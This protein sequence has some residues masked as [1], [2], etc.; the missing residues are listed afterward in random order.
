VSKNLFRAGIFFVLLLPARAQFGGN[1][2]DAI[3]YAV[4]ADGSG[5]FQAVAPFTE[6]S[7]QS[8]AAFRVTSLASV[9]LLTSEP[10]PLFRQIL[11]STPTE[12]FA[13]GIDIENTVGLHRLFLRP[14][15]TLQISG[16]LNPVGRIVGGANSFVSFPAG[17]DIDGDIA[18]ETETVLVWFRGQWPF[19]VPTT[20]RGPLGS[21]DTSGF[22][23]LFQTPGLVKFP[24]LLP[25][26][27]MAGLFPGA[28]WKQGID[29][30]M[31]DVD[32]ALGT[33]IRQLRL[34]P[35]IQTPTFRI[36]G[37]TH[38]FVLQGSVTITA[39]GLNTIALKQN[40]YAFLPANFA[41]TLANPK[42]YT[43][44]GASLP[45]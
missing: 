10:F 13:A 42:P 8:V 43:G 24:A 19:I 11:Y 33:M 1:A 18:F 35:G 41:V 29:L 27:N 28:G 25:W 17:L 44:P 21:P 26:S 22:E 32:A 39:A 40:D 16:M 31:L 2:G 36:P 15:K 14:V 34:R 23:Y 45:R 9:P 37:H 3:L 12:T 20:Q 38:L 7:P 30:K 5:D 6:N 4:T